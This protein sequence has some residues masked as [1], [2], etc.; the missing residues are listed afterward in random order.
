[1]ADRMEPTVQERLEWRG[2]NR[3]SYFQDGVPEDLVGGG[4]EVNPQKEKVL[5]NMTAMELPKDSTIQLFVSTDDQ[6]T[7]EE[8]VVALLEFVELLE[9]D[10]EQ[11]RL[12]AEEGPFRNW[13]E[14]RTITEDV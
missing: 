13:E 6:V 7:R 11:E 2:W 3:L 12:E 9:I 10:I 5:F 4:A 14:T 1:M 8:T